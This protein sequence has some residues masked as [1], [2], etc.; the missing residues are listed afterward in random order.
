MQLGAGGPHAVAQ[1]QAAAV[2][3]SIANG[4]A[5]AR[6]RC[7]LGH[8][9]G[10]EDVAAGA[11][12]DALQRTHQA[13]L[14]SF[15][16][17]ARGLVQASH[18]FAC[19]EGAVAAVVFVQARML[20]GAR[21]ARWHVPHLH[22]QHA[23][24]AAVGVLLTHQAAHAGLQQRLGTHLQ[25]GLL[26]GGKERGARLPLGHHAVAARR[27]LL[28]RRQMLAVGGH[29][30]VARVVEEFALGRV[31]GFV[32]WHGGAKA[33]AMAFQPALVGHAVVAKTL[34][35]GVAHHLAHFVAQVGVHELRAVHKACLFLLR[36]AATGI[37]HT[38]RQGAGTTAFKAV[39][40]Q[41]AG[42]FLA[43]LQRSTGPGSAPTH[44]HHLGTVAP[45][46]VFGT[47]HQQGWLNRCD[48]CA[49]AGARAG[50]GL[51]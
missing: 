19:A 11:Q 50:L 38:A 42:A 20:G 9:F 6:V 40:H 24:G 16:L 5:F 22:A 39:N 28:P 4:P 8:Q 48:G 26:Q 41:H 51:D 35:R 15:A 32:V 17:Q 33:H 7:V 23:P 27:R 13:W 3:A 2:A 44:H 37:H 47:C 36:G 49:A 1:A 18:G 29:H 46:Q 45:G 14:R 31:R 10:V 21:V 30:F 43:R 25:G 34:Q 12:N